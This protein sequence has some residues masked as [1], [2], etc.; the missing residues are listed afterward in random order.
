MPTVDYKILSQYES[1]FEENLL[2]IKLFYKEKKTKIESYGLLNYTIYTF[3]INGCN[4][5]KKINSLP[6][7]AK[8]SLEQMIQQN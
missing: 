6:H 1:I 2:K 3:E 8:I 7:I 4:T 5:R